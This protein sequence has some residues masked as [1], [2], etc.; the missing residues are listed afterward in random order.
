MGR[1]I[2]TYGTFDLFHV[3]HLN[4]LRKSKSLG[5]KLVVGISTDEFNET[6][7]KKSHFSFSD[8]CAIVSAC[9][10]VDE[11]LPETNWNQKIDDIHKYSVDLFVMGDDWQGKFD[12][13]KKYC[14]VTYLPRTEGVS[15]TLIRELIQLEATKRMLL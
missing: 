9:K 2:L 1:T 11:V 8:R 10:Y 14:E 12:F 3:G 13:L 15:T 4:I 5:E 7:G 6:K